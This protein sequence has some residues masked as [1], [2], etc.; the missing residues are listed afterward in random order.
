MGVK[1]QKPG[2]SGHPGGN[3]RIYV[4]VNYLN[5]RKTRVFNSS[6][7]A[8]DYADAVEYHLKHGEV[9]RVF[10]NPKPEPAAP[11]PTFKEASERWLVVDAPSFKPG[12]REDYKCILNLHVLPTFG[13][14]PLPSIASSDVEDWWGRIQAKGL[15]RVRQSRIRTVL[16]HVFTRA[17]KSKLVAENPV[18]AI[19]GRIGLEEGEV[20][21][22]E[23][24][25]EPE[26]A[27]LLHAAEVQ[28][29]RYYP[30][31][32]TIAST[33]VRLGEAV[34][35]QVG[36]VNLDRC[37]IA[38]RRA[39]RKRHEGSPKRGKPRTVDVPPSA[40]AVLRGWIDVVRAEAAVRGEE[41]CWLF[42]SGTGKPV[43]EPVIRDALTRILKAAGI[44]RRITP[45]ALRHTYASLALQRGVPLLVVSRQLG[46]KSIAITADIYGHLLPDATREA[47]AAWEAILTTPRRNP[48]ATPSTEAP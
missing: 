21:Q 38:V 20:R 35:L 10:S 46:H 41:A 4:R 29:P 2:E 3:R 48:D 36:D 25:S 19:A 18:A 27:N 37:K 42:P 16:N 43:D 11:A 17:V 33:G 34:G 14:R 47:A 9:D 12:T 5:H 8:Q 31:L 26:L 45:H 1:I 13:E 15:S 6:K 22:A 44:Q 32:L 7:A 40:I 24:L 39:I 28:E 23:W 30:I